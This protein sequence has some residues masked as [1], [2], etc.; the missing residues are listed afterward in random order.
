MT[1]HTVLTALRFYGYPVDAGGWHYWWVAWPVCL[2]WGAAMYLLITESARQTKRYGWQW[3][4]SVAGVYLASAIPLAFFTTQVEYRS[5]KPLLGWHGSLALQVL[6][7]VI[8]PVL[9]G[10]AACFWQEIPEHEPGHGGAPVFW[11]TRWW[12]FWSAAIGLGLALA[13]HWFD[14]AHYSIFEFHSWSKTFHDLSAYFALMGAGIFLVVPVLAYFGPSQGIWWIVLG[15]V[16]IVVALLVHE[17]A[18]PL[19]PSVYHPCA[20]WGQYW[21]RVIACPPG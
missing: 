7:P 14:A 16:L 13:F 20:E 2:V 8:L 19:P 6:D 5:L 17:A 15:L 1:V 21:G 18:F 12:Q 4:G 3:I 11:R 9:Y 10:L